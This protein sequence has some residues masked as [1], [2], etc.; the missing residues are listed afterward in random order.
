MSYG[1]DMTEGYS[2]KPE[3]LIK[4][5]LSLED[6]HPYPARFKVTVHKYFVKLQSPIRCDKRVGIFKKL[7]ID[8]FKLSTLAFMY[9]Q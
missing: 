2:P 7:P 8:R 3:L 9:V 6:K 1:R 5:P 4:R